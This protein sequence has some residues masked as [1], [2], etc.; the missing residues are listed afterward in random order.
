ME[1]ETNEYIPTAFDL[2]TQDKNIQMLKTVIPYLNSTRQK[3]FAL[4]VKFM[5][6][7]NVVTLFEK[8]PA[9]MSICS[10]EDSGDRN[11][12][13]LNDLKKFCTPAEQETID[14]LLGAF[15]MFSFGDSFAD[16]TP[17]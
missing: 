9:S 11:I 17:D 12:Q 6:L 8:T 10:S 14:M 16:S 7:R 4:M 3:N 1:Q 2:E 15:S 5:E 13:L